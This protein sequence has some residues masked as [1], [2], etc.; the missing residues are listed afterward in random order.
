MYLSSRRPTGNPSILFLY[1][2]FEFPISMPPVVPND[3][4]PA[5]NPGFSVALVTLTAGMLPTHPGFG[6]RLLFWTSN[7]DHFRGLHNSI[8]P[9]DSRLF[10]DETDPDGTVGS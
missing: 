10:L 5:P 4:V 3:R 2:P 1:L 7:R 8:D 6:L 9:L